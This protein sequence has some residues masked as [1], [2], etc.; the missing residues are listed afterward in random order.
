MPSLAN[1]DYRLIGA[2]QGSHAETWYRQLLHAQQ[3]RRPDGRYNLSCD[4]PAWLSNKA[5]DR[6]CKHVRR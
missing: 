4:C 2:I 1:G 5:G 3:P 6:T